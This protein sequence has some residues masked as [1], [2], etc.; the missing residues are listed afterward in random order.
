MTT[1]RTNIRPQRCDCCAREVAAGDGI[2]LEPYPL[3]DETGR[4]RR[5]GVICRDRMDC[6]IEQGRR[7]FA[8]DVNSGEN[9]LLPE[10]D[11]LP[12]GMTRIEGRVIP[13]EEFAAAYQALLEAHEARD[14]ALRREPDERY[15]RSQAKG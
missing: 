7:G 13:R 15:A 2:L 10:Q 9:Y 11:A 14:A 1:E 12:H 4:P 5:W 8:Y 6:L 3:R